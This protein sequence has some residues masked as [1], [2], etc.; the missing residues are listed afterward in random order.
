[1]R[2]FRKNYIPI[3]IAVII[4]VI[5]SVIIISYNYTVSE[6]FTNSADGGASRFPNAPNVG[7]KC[8]TSIYINRP[9]N[10][11]G[12]LSCPAGHD[13][14]TGN[15]ALCVKTSTWRCPSGLTLKSN[16]CYTTCP[17]HYYM[18]SGGIC[19]HKTNSSFIYVDQQ[20]PICP[21]R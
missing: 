10:N 14:D 1:M 9:K 3:L 16:K 11:R 6:L 21:N 2:F 7:T 18:T 13:I 17:T 5:I 12:L 15:K 20:L 8:Y 4:C 19:V